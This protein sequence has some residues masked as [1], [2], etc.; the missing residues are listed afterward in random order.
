[1]SDASLS[2]LEHSGAQIG[3]GERYPSLAGEGTTNIQERNGHHLAIFE[4]GHGKRLE[5]VGRA[6]DP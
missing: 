1:M 2:S 5:T 3:K 4:F 6:E